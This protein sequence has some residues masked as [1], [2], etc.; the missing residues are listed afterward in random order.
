MFGTLSPEITASQFA[1]ISVDEGNERGE[2]FPIA[3]LPLAEK[4]RDR[5][6]RKSMHVSPKARLSGPKLV[7]KIFRTGAKVNILKQ[8]CLWLSYRFGTHGT[9]ESL[10]AL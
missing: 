8:H 10:G 6:G 3:R 5:A 4:F 1:Q 9:D 7:H 2:R